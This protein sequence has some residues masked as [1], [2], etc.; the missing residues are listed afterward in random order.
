MSNN[1]KELLPI[2][3]VALLEGAQKRVMIYGVKQTDNETD[4]EY[5]YIGVVY[6]EGCMGD[7]SSFFFNHEQIDQVFYRGF[8]DE[9]RDAFIERLEAYYDQM[10]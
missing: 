1:I 5:D 3:S 9:E 6:P 8:E 10:Q 4:I 2:G 7:G